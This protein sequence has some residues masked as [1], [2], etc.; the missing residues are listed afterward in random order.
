MAD[1]AS[2]TPVSRPVVL[3]IDEDRSFNGM[4]WNARHGIFIQAENELLPF[5]R[6]P[7]VVFEMRGR[8]R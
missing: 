8:V 1:Y 2:N 5:R 6:P 3:P 7:Q 4:S